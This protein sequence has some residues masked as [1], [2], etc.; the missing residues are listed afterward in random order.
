MK[1]IMEYDQLSVIIGPSDYICKIERNFSDPVDLMFDFLFD[2]PEGIES[3]VITFR[4][5]GPRICKGYKI[6]GETEDGKPIKGTYYPPLFSV[7]I[8]GKVPERFGEFIP[9]K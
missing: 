6:E 2:T 1:Q 4:V 8:L 9:E 5:I 3:K 7:N